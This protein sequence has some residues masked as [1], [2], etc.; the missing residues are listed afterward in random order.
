MKPELKE[1]Y[2]KDSSL[3]KMNAS[4]QMRLFEQWAKENELNLKLTF[5]RRIESTPIR[6]AFYGIGASVL[7]L[8]LTGKGNNFY[9]LC[10]T[11]LFF[12]TYMKHP[13]IYEVEPAAR[14]NG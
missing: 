12:L 11:L 5:K 4:D 10:F 7:F 8:E 14:V 13:E 3:K 2:S 1:F 6:L 9:A